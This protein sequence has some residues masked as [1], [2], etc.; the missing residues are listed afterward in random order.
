MAVLAAGACERADSNGPPVRLVAG[1]SDTVIVNNVRPIQLPMRVL[2]AAG[3]TL[4]DSGVRYQWLAGIPI[5]VNVTGVATCAQPGDATVRA[6]LGPLVTR[7]LIR[8]RPVHKVRSLRMMNLVIG[9]PAHE[10]PFEAVDA[11]GRSVTLLTG[12][13]TVLDSTI[14]TVQGLRVSG[15]APGCTGLDMRIGDHV[16]H[17]SVHVYQRVDS[18]EQILPGQHVAVPVRLTSGE[19]RRWRLPAARELY[20]VTMIPD[21]DAQPAPRIAVTDAAC[22][23]GFDA[24]SYFCLAQRDAAVIVYHPPHAG[25]SPTQEWSGM[26]AIWRQEKP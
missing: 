15:R 8:C 11:A 9:G 16:A 26:L 4:P 18:P 21:G 20:F 5:S 22:V 23:P 17:A 10:L 13:V 25:P 7:L 2:D 24:Q 1:V 3:R 19:V 6:S 12:H 14:A